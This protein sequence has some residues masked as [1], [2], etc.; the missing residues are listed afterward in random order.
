MMKN[1]AVLLGSWLSCFVSV[2]CGPVVTPPGSD[3]STTRD[4]SPGE[5]TRSTPP[6]VTTAMATTSTT[7]PPV[8]VSGGS[9]DTGVLDTGEIPEDCSLL[10]QDC[11]A[12]YKCMPY[13][14]DGGNAWNDTMCV[15]LVDDPRAVGEP[16]MLESSELNGLDDCDGTSMCWDV[17]LETLEGTCVAF[18]IG[19]ESDPTCADPCDLCAIGGDGVLALCLPTCDPVAQN[20]G[21][22]QGCYPI[23][24]FFGCGPDASM[25]DMGI[26]SPCGFINDCPAGLFCIE[27][28]DLPN[29]EGGLGCC[30]PACAVG[31]FDSCPAL[32]PGTVCTPWFDE[33]PPLE[34][35]L[36]S[37]PGVCASP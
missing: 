13:S 25:P 20:C 6:A 32:F 37:E 10:A 36:A 23:S 7:S 8:D 30:T 11:P 17:D 5:D 33:P 9:V 35:C 15:P 18:C 16:C 34:R 19:D 24:D 31:G 1:R 4:P 12:G 3:G 29:C 21:D 28:F 26:G 22:G 27:S 2:G 14:N